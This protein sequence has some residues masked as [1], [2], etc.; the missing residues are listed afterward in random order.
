VTS[1]PSGVGYQPRTTPAERRAF[2]ELLRKLK[3]GGG[4]GGASYPPNGATGTVLAKASPA[5]DDVYWAPPAPKG[6]PGPAGPQGPV[7]PAG[8]TGATGTQGPPGVKGDTGSTGP[9]GAT[10]ATGS[11]GPPG[12]EGDPGPT[13]PAGADSTVPGPQGPAG[14][15]GIQGPQ[16]IPGTTGATGDTGP[17]GPGVAAGGT[18]GQVL[19]KNSVTDYDTEWVDQTA[20]VDTLWVGPEAPT[21]PSIELWYDT[22]EI[23]GPVV[24]M[25]KIFTVVGTAV[26]AQALSAETVT[27]TLNIPAQAVAG[28]LLIQ[29]LTRVD[30]SVAADNYIVRLRQN[31]ASGTELAQ[32]VA[33][34]GGGSTGG[35]IATHTPHTVVALP[36]ATAYTVVET[37]VR[38]SGTGTV[39]MYASGANHRLTA[40][41]MAG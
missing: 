3:A 12:P 41:W 5:D 7:G 22:D 27:A 19:A 9:T 37:T 39:T 31:N 28:T 11:Q 17:A 33:T 40:T 10:G 36:A 16:G 23:A 2:Y 29:S 21:D 8:P 30:K 15:Q 35:N 25:P 34:V 4:G 38:A 13:G 32:S 14:P 24:E 6:D 1:S 18:T 26:S 20:T